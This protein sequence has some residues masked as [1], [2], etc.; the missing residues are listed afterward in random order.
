MAEVLLKE[1]T[2]KNEREDVKEVLTMEIKHY[3]GVYK[4]S[5][6]KENICR[7]NEM[8]Y[9]SRQFTV[10]ADGNFNTKLGV[11]RKS[12]KKLEM[13]ENLVEENKEEMTNLWKDGQYQ[14]LVNMFCQKVAD[15]KIF[16]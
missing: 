12:A 2:P 4:L 13:L 15:S 16:K 14:T 3:N 1:F 5:V 10:F 9:T 7:N 11:G 8:G 6:L